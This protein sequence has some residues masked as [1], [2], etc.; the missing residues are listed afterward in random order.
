[1]LGATRRDGS[2]ESTGSYN[3]TVL[4]LRESGSRRLDGKESGKLTL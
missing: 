3:L 4:E 1:M 2:H